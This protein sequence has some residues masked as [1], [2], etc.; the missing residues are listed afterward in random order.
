MATPTAPAAPSPASTCSTPSK[1]PP[2]HS[3]N[4][5]PTPLFH[6]FGG[7]A[8][9]VGFSLPSLHLSTLRARISAH[10]ALHLTAAVLTPTLAYDAE[11]TL[12]DITPELFR[13]LERLAPFGHG[14]PEPV[15]LLRSAILAAPPRIIKDRHICLELA[16]PRTAATSPPDGHASD[17]TISALGWSRNTTTAPEQ[18]PT[19]WPS[20]AARLDLTAGSAIDLLVRLR[21]KT[22]PYANP[23]PPASNSNSATSALD[24]ARSR[25]PLRSPSPPLSHLAHEISGSSA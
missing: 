4:A 18:D 6:R 3:P 15:F 8:H 9:A 13:W 19:A 17:P 12:A 24:S 22:G 23:H 5:R 2:S 7:H 21:H 11:L 14:N 25:L 1:P 20:R 16:L 10:S